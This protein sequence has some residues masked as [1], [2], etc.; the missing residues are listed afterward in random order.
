MG[1]V[2]HRPMRTGTDNRMANT[3][4][5][6]VDG[7]DA[8][9]GSPHR[10]WRTIN[11]A[12]AQARPGDTI[13]F[14]PGRYR[15][16]I[17]PRHSGSADKPIVFRSQV[18]WKA[19]I[20]PDLDPGSGSDGAYAIQL[21]DLKF[22]RIEGLYIDG[23]S[24]GG[25]GQIIAC[26][27]I[28]VTRCCMV[29][30]GPSFE[31]CACDQIR[32][33]DNVFSKDRIHGDMLCIYDSDH[34]LFEGNAL[35]RAGHCPLRIAGCRYVVVRANSF[36]N[37]WGRNYEFW[38][39]GRILIER[40]VITD[41][42][43]SAYSADSRSKNLYDDGIF[44]F[45]R[46]FANNHTPLNSFSYLAWGASPTGRYREP[47]RLTN[48]RIYHNTIADNLG[49]GWELE[50]AH[51][52]AIIFQNNIFHRNDWVGGDVQIALRR[53]VSGDVRV[54]N[55]L[56]SGRKTGMRVIRNED[57]YQTL[58]QAE[59]EAGFPSF[60]SPR[61]WSRC[62]GNIDADPTFCDPANADYRLASGSP[63][64][65][66]G[67]PLTLAIGHGRG[68]VL[69]VSDGRPFFDGF[70]IE[71]ETGD[72]IAVGTP[73]QL[74]RIR[75]VELRYY[76]P[77][78]LHL[79][80]E[81]TWQ[82]GA[83][84]SLPWTG[85]A[86]DLGA[87]QTG[88][89]GHESVYVLVTNAYPEPG[90]RIRFHLDAPANI[91][92]VWWSFG[93]GSY[94]SEPEP[95]HAYEREGTYA[96]VVHVTFKG[97][98]RAIDVVRVKVAIPRASHLPL[99]HAD[100]DP[101]TRDSQWGHYFKF[102]RIWLTGFE[103]R[104]RP[105][106]KGYAIRL[107]YDPA[108]ENRAAAVIAP[109]LW[110]IEQYPI[111]QFAYNIKPDTPVSIC[112]APFDSP[113]WPRG[114]ILGGTFDHPIGDY[115]DLGGCELIADHTWRQATVDLRVIRRS[116]PELTH[117]YRFMF[118]TDWRRKAGQEFWF[119]RFAILPPDTTL[120]FPERDLSDFLATIVG[121]ID[122]PEEW[123]VFALPP[124]TD[125]IVPQDVLRSLPNR[126]EVAGQ[127]IEPRRVRAKRNQFDFRTLWGSDDLKGRIGYAVVHLRSSTAQTVTLGFGA[128]WKLQVWLNGTTVLDTTCLDYQQWPP[129]INDHRVNVR[130]IEGHNV[131][132]ARL[133]SGRASSVLAMSGPRELRAMDFSSILF[134]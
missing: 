133:I 117:L 66:A 49:F 64:I 92:S 114:F 11:H 116:Y 96:A 76:Q 60:Q 123:T 105:D 29:N 84:V 39:T 111:I 125:E 21:R 65:C 132:V 5:I 51:V 63:A 45:N 54:T 30:A 14:L 55:N 104:P 130:L 121:D 37:D 13:V 12:N 118:F 91:E 113:H 35:Q 98:G 2:M 9:P 58:E 124:G 119:D 71:G 15:G 101:L 26:Q 34:V 85:N 81:V 107:F 16:V 32:M 103:H 122:F 86:P 33:T 24:R 25:W 69:P 115:V 131:L 43:D 126:I 77:A 120:D 38:A 109:G 88:H 41:S 61:F 97:G 93:D 50:G 53:G 75:H 40:N 72:L 90:Q 31:V 46:V 79:D 48:S 1:S 87:Y 110:P 36:H 28:T 52:S 94:S 42:S 95:Q 67:T 102:Y 82:D 44:R 57:T 59:E 112:V 83:P 22:I 127:S 4:Y 128:D 10:P 78:L 106:N 19:Q 8:W 56:I 20:E 73:H 23:K 47:F 80:R 129:S 27:Y 17:Q 6:S 74:A 7:N 108:K 70:G 62:N 99:V 18:P 89:P 3:Y 100:F 68:C 134:D